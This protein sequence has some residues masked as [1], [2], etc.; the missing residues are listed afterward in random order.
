MFHL[1]RRL[2]KRVNPY[3]SIIVLS[4]TTRYPGFQITCYPDYSA[5]CPRY[6]TNC[7]TVRNPHKGIQQPRFGWLAMTSVWWITKP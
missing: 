1:V 3:G 2:K 6:L 7:I 4:I 5:S